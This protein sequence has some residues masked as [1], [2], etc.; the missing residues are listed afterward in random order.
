MT[1]ATP[2][3][4]GVFGKGYDPGYATAVVGVLLAAS[5][6]RPGFDMWSARMRAER[7]VTPVLWANSSYVAIL[8]VLL[9]LLVPRWGALGAAVSVTCGALW[10]AAVGFVGIRRLGRTILPLTPAPPAL[11]GGTT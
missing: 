5:A 8:L 4:F 11:E 2:V 1:A 9:L 10:L 3:I 7:R 6:I